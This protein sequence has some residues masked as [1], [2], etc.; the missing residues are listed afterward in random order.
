MTRPAPRTVNHRTLVGHARRQR[1][2]EK[3]LE[4]AMQVFAEQRDKPPVIDDFIRSAGVARGTF[5]NYFRT[6]QELLDA[7]VAW[8]TDDVIKSIE[9]EIRAYD[10]PA[11]RLA[12]ACRLF[13]RL[14][15]SDRAWC[16]FLVRAPQIGVLTRRRLRSDLDQGNRAG[17][18]HIEHPEAA[19]DLVTGIMQQALRR[20]A[21]RRRGY[22]RET[23]VSMMLRGL[24]ASDSTVAR[25]LSTGLPTLQRA[26]KSEALFETDRRGTTRG[27]TSKS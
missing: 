6:T 4:S 5:Y 8:S 11:L 17:L 1:T 9:Q 12:T 25:V 13:L 26:V 24:G 16:A 2:R 20:V 7:T 14:A 19:Y 27:V 3:I 10:D 15:E 22:A 18:F 23:L 21:S